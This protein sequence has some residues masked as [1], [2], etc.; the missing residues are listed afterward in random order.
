[1]QA[2]TWTPSPLTRRI[3]TRRP[4][5]KHLGFGVCKV[6]G[7]ANLPTH[8]L[9]RSQLLTVQEGA[10]GGAKIHEEDLAQPVSQHQRMG[11][12]CAGR[13]QTDIRLRTPLFGEAILDPPP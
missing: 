5:L 4:E 11:S 8:D 2:G 13:R 7:D 3:S 12:G 6:C 10:V 1:M 9:P